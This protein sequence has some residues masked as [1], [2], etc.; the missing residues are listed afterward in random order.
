MNGVRRFLGGGGSS[1]LTSPPPSTEAQPSLPPLI[2]S[3]KAS[4]PPQS[5]SPDSS[6]KMATTALHM[7]KDRQKAQPLPPSLDEDI[8]NTSYHSGRSSNTASLAHSSP[9]SFPT[10][11]PI[12]RPVAGPSSS[13]VAPPNNASSRT[14]GSGSE[15]RQSGLRLNTRDELLMSLLASEAVVDSRDFDILSAEDVEE[16]K[17]VS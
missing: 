3:G 7:R 6:K 15:G 11:S 4:W 12:R 9:T 17:K 16:L 2:I 8:A 13:R 10:S 14:S 5:V 1:S